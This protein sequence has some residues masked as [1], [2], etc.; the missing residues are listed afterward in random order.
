MCDGREEI[1]MLA[2]MMLI[3]LKDIFDSQLGIEGRK[4]MFKGVC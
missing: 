4:E 2:S 1:L 3:S